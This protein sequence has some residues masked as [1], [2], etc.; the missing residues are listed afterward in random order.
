LLSTFLLTLIIAIAI[1]IVI[2]IA[3]AIVIVMTILTGAPP[4]STTFA[5]LMS[6]T[7]PPVLRKVYDDVKFLVGGLNKHAGPE[8]NAVVTARF[9]KSKKDV[10]R[11]VYIRCDCEGKASLNSGGFES[12]FAVAHDS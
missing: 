8:G 10:D 2:T 6:L 7:S 4:V 5:G 12:V 1:T 9:K 11:I 3:I